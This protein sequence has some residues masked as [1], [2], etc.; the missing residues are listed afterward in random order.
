MHNPLRSEADAF[1]AVVIVA[2]ALGV[3]VAI[4]VLWSST[5]GAIALAVEVG[6]GAGLAWRGARGSLPKT[7]EVAHNADATYRVLVVANQTVGGRALLEEIKNRCKGRDSEILVVVPALTASQLEHW[8]SDVDGAIEDARERLEVSL[9]T[10]KR[11]GLNARGDVGDH[12][13]PNASIEDALRFFPA[14]EVI[15]STHP[16][17]KSR[18]LEQGVV[19]RARQEVPLPVTHV[20]VDL[21]AESVARP[22]G[23]AA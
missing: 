12:H 4:G 10:M 3:V 18:W 13:E 6:V 23:S 20:V 11:A 1:R 21:E 17:E 14:D 9:R 8:A 5:A 22:A 2:V 16:P 19:D 7:A 15:I